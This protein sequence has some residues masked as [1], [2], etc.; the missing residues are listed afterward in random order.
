MHKDLRELIKSFLPPTTTEVILNTLKYLKRDSLFSIAGHVIQVYYG[1]KYNDNVKEYEHVFAFKRICHN[2]LIAINVF[3][4]WRYNYIIND[5]L[6]MD[7]DDPRNWLMMI[8]EKAQA[9]NNR[10]HCRLMRAITNNFLNDIKSYTSFT[11]EGSF[12]GQQN[13]IR[14]KYVYP[15][16]YYI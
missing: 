15:Y 14:E 12:V 1:G 11:R 5:F 3:L 7:I 13:L 8:I 6:T 10:S 9:K 16:E 2:V 4:K